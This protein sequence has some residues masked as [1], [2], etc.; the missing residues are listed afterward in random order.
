MFKWNKNFQLTFILYVKLLFEY[1]KYGSD[2][3]IITDYRYTYIMQ[4][5][6]SCIGIF[7]SK[8]HSNNQI[9]FNKRILYILYYIN[10]RKFSYI[11][12]PNL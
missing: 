6:Y 9:I 3:L 10:C 12:I 4:I 11:I 2:N 7:S 8:M 1:L 5:L